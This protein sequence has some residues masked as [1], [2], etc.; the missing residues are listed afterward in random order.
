MLK[1]LYAIF[2]KNPKKHYNNKVK[3]IK[4]KLKQKNE[5]FKKRRKT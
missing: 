3:A 1:C 5:Y 2:A 4:F